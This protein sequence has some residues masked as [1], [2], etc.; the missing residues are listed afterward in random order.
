[1]ALVTLEAHGL[2]SRVEHELAAKCGNWQ[3]LQIMKKQYGK[4]K[5]YPPTCEGLTR[6]ERLLWY[7]NNQPKIQLDNERCSQSSNY[8]QLQLARGVKAVEETEEE[9]EARSRTRSEALAWYRNGG[10]EKLEEEE[11]ILRNCGTWQQYH[12]KTRGRA[13]A[14]D[15]DQ[16]ITKSER[17]LWYR[18]GGGE[19]QVEARNQLCRESD[20][21]V[22]YKLTR[23][24]RLHAEDLTQ[25]MNRHWSQFRSKEEL[26]EHLTHLRNEG[27]QEREEIRSEV[28]RRVAGRASMA[29]AC[30]E[31][32]RHPWE[33]EELE[34]EESR[35]MVKEESREE[36]IEQLR[37]TTEEMLTSRT[38]YLVSTRALALRAMKEDEEAVASSRSV[39]R[40]QTVVQQGA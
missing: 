21:W 37:K 35:R 36:R 3:Q 23:D 19:A 18:Y 4:E 14:R 15:L 16:E 29:K 12:L 9:K 22:Q 17:L 25:S 27:F 20:N 24:T 10:R 38:E 39:R 31:A 8:R 34:E 1:M 32:Y 6:S 26:S 11:E 30:Y 7:R 33:A 2:E 28:R 13:E 5:V 40:T